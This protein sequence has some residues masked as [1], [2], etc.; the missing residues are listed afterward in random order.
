MPG[1]EYDA[2]Q[3]SYSTL[4]PRLAEVSEIFYA[5]LFARH[6]DVRRLF[7]ADM[8]LQVGH[9]RAALALI[10]RNVSVLKSLEGPLM[11]LGAQH[12][13]YGARPEHY[14][15]VRDLLAESIACVMGP[16]WTPDLEAEWKR[17]LEWVCNVMLR[18]AALG[19]I[20]D[21]SAIHIKVEPPKTRKYLS[22]EGR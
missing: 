21:P 3:K 4:G 13:S 9:L 17:L 15:I 16:A 20:G 1:D 19:L 14:P 11:E 6:P 18:G 5:R 7:P 22:S 10:G 12:V 8:G 2:I